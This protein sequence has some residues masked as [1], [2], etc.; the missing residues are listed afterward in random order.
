MAV[1][2][3]FNRYYN[4]MFLRLQEEYPGIKGSSAYKATPATFP[5]IYLSQIDGSTALTTLSGTED[6]INLGLQTE[7][8]SKTSAAEARGIANSLR[9]IMIDFG[10][11]CSYFRPVANISDASIHRFIAR[12]ERLET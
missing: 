8:Y 2:D 4:D 5:H 3:N 7:I 11:K 12:F 9:T 1:K 10:F 6:G